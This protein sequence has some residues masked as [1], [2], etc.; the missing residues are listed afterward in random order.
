MRKRIRVKSEWMVRMQ[1]V[2]WTVKMSLGKLKSLRGT[3]CSRMWGSESIK[4]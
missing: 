2:G 3:A 1:F 4:C